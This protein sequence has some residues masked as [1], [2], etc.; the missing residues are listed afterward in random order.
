MAMHRIKTSIWTLGCAIVLGLVGGAAAALDI[1]ESTDFGA[2]T[3]RMG[4]EV[5][6]LE[7]GT[8]IFEGRLRGEAAF[9]L[10]R[11]VINFSLDAAD[12]IEDIRLDYLGGTV[13]GFEA[14]DIDLRLS[15][16]YGRFFNQQAWPFDALGAPVRIDFIPAALA[17]FA[18]R[19][20]APDAHVRI[21]FGKGSGRLPIAYDVA[22]RL[23]IV[24]AP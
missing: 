20:D 12:R 13:T 8:N 3:A 4:G 23:V 11:D 10:D 19:T 21:G 7:P 9:P 18:A 1:S 14:L 24:V 22:Y 17:L 6:V 15:C 2:Q 5:H 16:D